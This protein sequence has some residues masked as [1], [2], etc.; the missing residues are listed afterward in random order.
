MLSMIRNE[1]IKVRRTQFF[2]ASF[3]F[4]LLSPVFSLLLMSVET[5]GF[6]MGDFNRLNILLLSLVGTRTIIPVIGMYLIKLELDQGGFHSNFLAP[7]NRSKFL[8]AKIITAMLWSV[9]LLVFSAVCV[10]GTELV[11]FKDFQIIKLLIV[12]LRSYLYIFFY[13]ISIQMLGMLLTFVL[14]NIIYPIILFLGF[15]ILG[16][17]IQL[18]DY[19]EY[20]PSI[21]P[22]YIIG[23]EVEIHHVV[24][25]WV[26]VLMT[27]VISYMLLNLMIITRDYK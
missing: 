16:Y 21:L 3:L 6:I 12:D 2:Y 24:I 23:V 14:Q 17:I 10:V 25:A 9:L 7:V 18:F 27:F 26:M 8:L 4:M 22:E 15:I 13:G 20:L 1:I 5:N 11:L 19:L